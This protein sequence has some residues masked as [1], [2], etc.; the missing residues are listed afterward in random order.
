MDFL[1]E[2]F[3]S[4]ALT[5]E[6]FSKAVTDKGFKIV[7]LSKGEYV[8][9]SK[10][11][12]DLQSRDEQITTLTGNIETRDKDL[13]EVK[14]K[15]ESAGADADKINKLTADLSEL[16]TKYDTDTADYKAQLDKQAYSFAA[17]EFAGTQKFTSEAAK[18]EFI[19]SLEE[20][21]LKLDGGKIMGVTDFFEQYKKDNAD[22]FAAAEDKNPHFVDKTGSGGMHTGD[23]NPFI[24]NMHFVGVR[25]HDEKK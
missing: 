14:K 24:T 18:R 11:D 23:D 7:D 20:K 8:S 5:W 22:S 17:R 12:T 10:Y 4:G 19:R 3:N 16:Q 25:A 6:Q 9:K 15:L 13:A 2:L 21:G 1:K